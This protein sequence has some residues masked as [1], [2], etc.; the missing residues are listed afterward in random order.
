MLE[1]Y[2]SINPKVEYLPE[3]NPKAE[4]GWEG[5]KALWY[6]CAKY[7]GKPTKVFAYIGYPDVKEGTKVPAIVL[8]HGGGGHAFAHWVK[9]W[10]DRGYA[11]IAMDTEGYFPAEDKK[12]LTGIEGEPKEWYVHEL[13]G[14][15]KD[16]T[17]TVGPCNDEMKNPEIAVS[18][19]WIYHAIATTILAHNILL[20]DE[21]VDETKIGITGVSWGSVITSLA[22]GYDS[23]YAFAIPIYG[24][25]YLEYADTNVC[26]GFK[27]SKTREQWSAADRLTNAQFPILWYCGL[28][29]AAFCSYSNSLSYLD[30]KAT[31]SYI[32]IQEDL[33]HSHVD[34]WNRAEGYHFAD[35][36]L[37][38]KKPFITVEEGT[39][40]ICIPEGHEDVKARLLYFTEDFQFNEESQPMNKAKI[41]PV[42]IEGNTMKVEVPQGAFCYYIEFTSKVNGVEIVSTTE[43]F[44]KN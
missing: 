16:E 24:S 2:L 38:G 23:R 18:E 6:E 29:D 19:Q 30:T 27:N 11:A 33:M 26:R 31:G 14:S 32:S 40:A 22:I 15:L 7:E 5:V 1:Q 4:T 36:V 42:D 35:C 37:N 28:Y 34:A 9:K 44:K 10:N 13:Y 17:Y 39:S 25:A 3:Y 20:A 41:I 8:V 21:R 12:G 43:W